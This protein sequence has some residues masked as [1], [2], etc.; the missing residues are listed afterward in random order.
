VARAKFCRHAKVG[1]VGW[2]RAGGFAER[3]L[4]SLNSSTADERIATQGLSLHLLICNEVEHLPAAMN[5]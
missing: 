2:Q 1:A 3:L 5:V 4:D